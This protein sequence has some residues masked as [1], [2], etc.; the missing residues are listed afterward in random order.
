MWTTNEEKWKYTAL[1]MG[2][3]ASVYIAAKYFSMGPCFAISTPKPKLI[4]SKEKIHPLTGYVNEHGV[5]L[6][7]SQEDLIADTQEKFPNDAVMVASPDVAALLANLIRI[8]N[9]KRG[10]EVGVFTG[11]TTLTMAMAMPK[12]DSKLIA[13]D[14]SDTYAS[15]G[16]KY[17]KLSNVDHIIDLR[18]GQAIITLDDMLLNPQN[19]ESFDFAFIDADKVNY[20][21]YY[22]RVLKLLRKGGWIVFDNVFQGGYVVETTVPERRKKDVTA[23]RALN[24]KLK[25]DHR[26][27]ISMLEMSDGITLVVKN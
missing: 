26:V 4:A 23:I 8:G 12:D 13:L 24:E 25:N 7:R 16:K 14:I 22:E 21:P 27:S 18:L 20:D 11:Y 19:L 5:R 1:A 2:G 10:I 6:T 17:W 15:L 3:V 9:C